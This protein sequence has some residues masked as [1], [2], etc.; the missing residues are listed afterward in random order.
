MYLGV[1]LF[2][3]SVSFNFDEN[4]CEGLRE[5]YVKDK[6]CVFSEK[7][8]SMKNVYQ[9]H[10]LTTNMNTCSDAQ[11]VYT[12]FGCCEQPSN[13]LFDVNA[14]RM[15]G[16]KYQATLN[17]FKRANFATNLE[18]N[19]IKKVSIKTCNPGKFPV[20]LSVQN[21]SYINPMEDIKDAILFTEHTAAW[22]P[23]CQSAYRNFVTAAYEWKKHTESHN[24]SKGKAYFLNIHQD[25]NTEI[26]FIAS[27][28]NNAKSIYKKIDDGIEVS[29][30][31]EELGILHVNDD[32]SYRIEKNELESNDEY[33]PM[34]DFLSSMIGVSEYP[35]LRMFK[36]TQVILYTTGSQERDF[37]GMIKTLTD[38][39]FESITKFKRHYIDNTYYGVEYENGYIQAVMHSDGRITAIKTPIFD[40]TQD[41]ESFPYSIPY[42]ATKTSELEYVAELNPPLEARIIGLSD[43]YGILLDKMKVT[44]K[45]IKVVLKN[46]TT[47]EGAI[48]Y[49]RIH[50]V[51][52]L[53]SAFDD[54]VLSLVDQ[55]VPVFKYT[56]QAP[57]IR[58]GS[59]YQSYTPYVSNLKDPIANVPNYIGDPE[60]IYK[61]IY[62]NATDEIGLRTDVVSNSFTLNGKTLYVYMYPNNFMGN[63]S[64]YETIAQSIGAIKDIDFLNKLMTTYQN[65]VYSAFANAC[66]DIVPN[67][68]VDKS[69]LNSLPSSLVNSN[70]RINICNYRV[71]SGLTPVTAS[72]NTDR[73]TISISNPT[74][75]NHKYTFF[76]RTLDEESL[77]K[78]CIGDNLC[79]FISE[80]QFV[81][82]PPAPP[83]TPPSLRS[84]KLNEI[85]YQN[86]I[87]EI[88][89]T[90][91]SDW[92]KTYHQLA[93][94]YGAIGKNKTLIERHLI[95]DLC[96]DDTYENAWMTAC[97][98]QDPFEKQERAVDYTLLVHPNIS[99]V[100]AVRSHVSL[101]EKDGAC[102]YRKIMKYPLSGTTSWTQRGICYIWNPTYK[103][104]NYRMFRYIGSNEEI[105]DGKCTELRQC[106][107][108]I[109]KN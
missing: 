90:N 104:S 11:K 85:M 39:K 54:D 57:T 58:N 29:Y 30:S 4:T 34:N 45:E 26:G 8:F 25:S 24:S 102:K 40:E 62:E 6:C 94:E 53:S 20:S 23:S 91:A 108:F 47:M 13:I 35:T 89:M 98:G 27:C 19:E 48:E 74:T 87:Y 9:N 42:V 109:E 81:A 28:E 16:W 77:Q 22:C 60:S 75:L 103:N 100:S 73:P 107:F 92:S 71:M 51:H 5:R 105:Y 31:A 52:S 67:I 33:I 99:D 7:N 72:S 43:K 68:Y 82:P 96:S 97:S 44:V 66:M 46:S 79:I 1:S 63:D 65:Y 69:L 106:I 55:Y 83:S 80:N 32:D 64:S 56:H 70:P 38:D 37:I 17:N 10:P 41:H 21:N 84:T 12:E 3:A 93:V 18:N 61:D 101:G 95:R 59:G 76:T 86:K 49:Y 15:T 36:G 50:R 2:L 14:T 78:P 88:K